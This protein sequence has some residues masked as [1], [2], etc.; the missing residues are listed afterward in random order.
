MCS[1]LLER[2]LPRTFTHTMNTRQLQAA[3]GTLSGYASTGIVI[4]L[5][6]AMLL[7]GPKK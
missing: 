5:Q 4:T 6:A 2:M 7:P 1:V 3:E